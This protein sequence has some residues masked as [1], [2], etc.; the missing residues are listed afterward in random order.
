[1]QNPPDAA[2]VCR[3]PKRCSPH[4]D[5]VPLFAPIRRPS[6]VLGYSPLRV[7]GRRSNR[8]HLMPTSGKPRSHLPRVFADSRGLW[9][10]VGAA[11]QDLHAIELPWQSETIFDNNTLLPTIYESSEARS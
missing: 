11:N 7:I 9:R 10:K 6:I 2:W 5:A 3:D 4:I 8:S 1:M